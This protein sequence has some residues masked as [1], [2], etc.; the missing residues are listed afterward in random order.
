MSQERAEELL[1]TRGAITGSTAAGVNKK[2][3]I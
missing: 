2:L 3:E 1:Q